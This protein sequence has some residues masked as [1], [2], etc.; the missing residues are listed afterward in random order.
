MPAKEVTIG[1]L[2]A[3]MNPVVDKWEIGIVVDIKNKYSINFPETCNYSVKWFHS[4][5]TVSN[6]SYAYVID[7]TNNYNTNLF[8]EE[9]T[10]NFS[11]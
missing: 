8:N 1:T 2:V 5:E 10:F 6:Y 7:I 11:N 3:R 4:G 9:N